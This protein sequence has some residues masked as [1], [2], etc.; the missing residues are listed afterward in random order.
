VTAPTDGVTV[1]V[2]DDSEDQRMLLRRYFEK[3]GCAVVDAATAEEAI[4]ACEQRVPDLIVID[5]LLP[6]IDGWDLAARLG[7]QYPTSAI[8]ITSVLDPEDYPES[9]ATMPKP[10]SGDDVRRVLREHVPKWTDR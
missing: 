8:A 5:L 1:L 6:G 9:H 2:V 3:A 7:E 4:V 10:V